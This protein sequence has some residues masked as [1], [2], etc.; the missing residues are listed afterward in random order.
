M[1]LSIQSL[2][3]ETTLFLHFNATPI[4]AGLQGND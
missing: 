1:T 3:N 2:K 4:P